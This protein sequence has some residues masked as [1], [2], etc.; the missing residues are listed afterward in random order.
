MEFKL[1]KIS[2]MY[3]DEEKEVKRDLVLRVDSDFEILHF[4]FI[5]DIKMTGGMSLTKKELEVLRDYINLI[6]KNKI[7]K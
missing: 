1:E 2:T 6:L 7:L 5:D 3:P 4:D